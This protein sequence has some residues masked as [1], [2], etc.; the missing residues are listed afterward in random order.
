MPEPDLTDPGNP[1]WTAEDFARAKDPQS[2]PPG[3]LAAFPRTLA[4]MRGPGKKPRKLQQTLRLDPDVLACFKSEGRL[5][6]RRIKA[7]LRE[8]M[9]QGR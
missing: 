7:V 5:W 1:E 2:L 4:R 9:E 3:I 6:Q 8:V